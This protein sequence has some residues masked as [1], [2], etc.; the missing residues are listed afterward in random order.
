MA[1]LP[2]ICYQSL[3]PET[4]VKLRLRLAS[5]QTKLQS[6][7]E[8]PTQIIGGTKNAPLTITVRYADSDQH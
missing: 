4:F 3:T 6:L 8:D 2:I 7:N 5:L 1:A